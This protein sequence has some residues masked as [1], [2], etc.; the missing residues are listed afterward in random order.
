[1]YRATY[2]GMY[3]ILFL[4][5]GA[6]WYLKK[7]VRIK[8]DFEDSS[9]AENKIYSIRKV[10]I[11]L[12]LI[13]F[14]LYL[15]QIFANISIVLVYGYQALYDSNLNTVPKWMSL[16][17]DFF[18]P[19]VIALY[20]SCQYQKR[21]IKIVTILA[22][23]GI[24]LP[25]FFLGGRSNAMIVFT[26]FL[27]V[28]SLFNKFNTRKILILSGILMIM[29]SSFAVIALTRGNSNKSLAAMESAYHSVDN[30]VASTIS[31]MG[32]S[33]Y[34]LCHCMD[35]FPEK[36]D[37]RYGD[38]YLYAMTSIIPNLGFWEEHPAKT[39]ANLGEWLKNYLDLGFG[40]G[41]SLTAEAYVNFG[42][43]GFIFFLIYGYYMAK[44]FRYINSNY[45]EANPFLLV[46]CLVFLWFSIKTVR[47]SFLGTVR[48]F[49]YYALPMYYMFVY[50]YKKHFKL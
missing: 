10:A 35:I 22:F 46:V 11:Y 30:P 31:E 33:M 37:F 2:V 40:P 48:A 3:F 18:E 24:L 28:Y 13:S 15:Y 41:F 19:S 47:N 25:P 38:S 5:F 39:H 14:P 29:F 12:C 7:A 43:F 23:W 45:I 36:Q 9:N 26:I 21:N 20:F 32:F 1:M 27:I 34:P 50:H 8:S 42:Y 16:V 6:L 49:F 44:G 4:H 17:G